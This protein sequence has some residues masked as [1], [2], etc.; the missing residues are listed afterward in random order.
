MKYWISRIQI[1]LLKHLKFYPMG[2]EDSGAFGDGFKKVLKILYRERKAD[3]SYQK[4]PRLMHRATGKKLFGEHSFDSSIENWSTPT[5]LKYWISRIQILL[6]KHR[7]GY[8]VRTLRTASIST[9]NRAFRDWDRNIQ[10]Q[11]YLRVQRSMS[12]EEDIFR[13]HTSMYVSES[14]S[15]FFS[16]RCATKPGFCLEYAMKETESGLATVTST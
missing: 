15:F 13:P 11:E 6:L 12:A 14:E 9:T 3:P 7:I 2:V 4:G 5:F 1:L 8:K 10:S 16:M